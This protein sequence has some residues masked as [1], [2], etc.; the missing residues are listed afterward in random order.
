MAHVESCHRHHLWLPTGCRDSLLHGKRILICESRQTL[1][2]VTKKV[3]FFGG[4]EGELF[5]PVSG[6][7]MSWK[8]IQIVLF[9]WLDLLDYEFLNQM[10]DLDE[11]QFG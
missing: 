9:V 7:G 3:P 8:I 5:R 10:L 2:R 6:V 4:M 11:L 1:G